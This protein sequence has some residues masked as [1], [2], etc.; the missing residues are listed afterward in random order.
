MKKRLRLIIIGFSVSFAMMAALSLFALRQFSSL[1][2]YSD[3]VDHTNRVISQL[4][5]I[6]NLLQEIDVK[7]RGYMISRDS[8][9]IRELNTINTI[10]L[11]ETKKLQ[12]LLKKD[13]SQK[14]FLI[15]LRDKLIEKRDNT[16]KNINYVDSSKTGVLSPYFEIGKDIRQSSGDLLQKMRNNEDEALQN[17]FRSKIYYQQIT[18]NTIKYLL[19]VFSIIT[20]FLFL[21]MIRELRKRMAYQDELQNTIADLKQSHKELEQIAYA[22]SHDL[23]EPLRKIQ[24]FSNRLLF[25]KK[26]ELDEESKN[27]LHRINSSASR[28]HELIDDLM[29][30]TS[31]VKEEGMDEVNLNTVLNSVISDLDEK[32]KEKNVNVQVEALPEVFGHHRQIQLLFRSLID[33][34]IK[35]A[36]ENVSPVISVR[37]DR[38]NGEELKELHLGLETQHF[39]RITIADNGI[40]FENKFINKM[41]RIFQSLHNKESEYSGKGVGLAICQRVMVN[42]NGYI[43]AHG[44]PGVGATFRLYFPIK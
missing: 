8:V 21:L 35:F 16:R 41:F 43:I 10:I 5:I 36:R 44:H 24:I 32:I 34:S 11:P 33:N 1:V 6:E 23:Q 37:S 20:I 28:M 4:F 30:L 19:S 15:L 31:L 40:G 25:V 26:T 27:T 29:N 2:E 7:E 39:H 18:Y 14:E 9:F 42:H 38:V 17:K 12:K 3:Q 13:P 22:V